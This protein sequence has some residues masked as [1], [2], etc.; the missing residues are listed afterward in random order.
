MDIKIT[1]CFLD[2]VTKD[3]SVNL[4]L[5]FYFYFFNGFMMLLI[6]CFCRKFPFLLFL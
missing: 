2:L 3:E 6:V 1:S 4:F 5:D